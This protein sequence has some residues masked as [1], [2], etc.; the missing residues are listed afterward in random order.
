MKNQVH[1]STCC[2]SNC[3]TEVTK[4]GF[5]EA[6]SKATT[7]AAGNMR[8]PIRIMLLDCPTEEAMIRRL[9]KDDPVVKQLEFNLIQRILAVTHHADSL[10]HILDGIRSLGFKPEVHKDGTTPSQ[11]K[12]QHRSWWPIALAAL[13]ALASEI[14]H[15]NNAS[16]WLTAGLALLAIV[17]GGPH[18]YKKGWLA[19]RH[20]NLN[21]N[22]LMSIAVTGAIL[23]GQWPE[24]AM[25]MVLF[26]LAE[27]IESRSL[28]RARRAISGLMELAPEQ[29]TVQQAD[30]T[31]LNMPSR[32]VKLDQIVRIDPGQQ[33]PLD[34][35]LINGH[36]DI[37]Q[38]PITGES[39]PVS[40][41]IG[42]T[43]YAG[44]INL[45]G[46]F[47]YRVTA[48]STNSTLA[49]IIH[50]VEEAQHA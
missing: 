46:A 39:M 17:I 49:R 48:T 23:I 36:S 16:L 43:V 7:T 30:G 11:N 32:E 40:K 37:N 28:E 1:L 15:Y 29:A 42:D 5:N 38:A 10:D 21:I 50:R 27:V 26:S 31:W 25:V 6:P 3:S 18:T 45:H 14:S 24:A 19:I 22:A 2:N 47:E 35:E 13:I 8:T 4:P 9:F 33:I 20:G 34:G 44:T 12:E 41:S